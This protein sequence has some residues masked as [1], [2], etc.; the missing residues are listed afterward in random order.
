MM[1][2]P[3]PAAGSALIIVLWVMVVLSSVALAFSYHTRLDIQM[4]GYQV[5]RQQARSL[6]RAG[7]TRALVLLRDDML[8]DNDLLKD[9]DLVPVKNEDKGFKYD[10]YAEGWGNNPDLLRD[11]EFGEG[12]FSVEIRDLAEKINLNAAWLNVDVLKQLLILLGNDERDAQRLAALMVDWRDPDPNATDAG[13]RASFSDT[14]SEDTYWN[15]D[16][17]AREIERGGPRFVIKNAPYDSM[18]EVLLLLDHLKMSPDILY[19]EEPRSEDFDDLP[20][21]ARSDDRRL[22]GLMEV[23]TVHGQSAVNLNTVK[24]TCLAA[25]LHPIIGDDAE[26][27]ARNIDDYRK[28]NDRRF[29]TRD[30][31]FFRDINNAD[32]DDMDLANITGVDPQVVANLKRMGAVSSARFLVISTGRVRDVKYTVRAV[33]TRSFLP[34]E[35]LGRDPLDQTQVVDLRQLSPREKEQVRFIFEAYEDS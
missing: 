33:V 12:S 35:Q 21:R 14:T 9:D 26:R 15:P 2:R 5:Q 25:M 3:L 24:R 4:A 16:Q 18:E 32:G 23:C 28:G 7:V 27:V 30:D 34:E 19:G 22:R 6:A 8:K 17:D 29:G 13:E 31:R 10:A 11:V 1:R 20:D